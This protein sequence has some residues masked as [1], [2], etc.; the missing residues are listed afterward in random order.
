MISFVV[1]SVGVRAL[2][3]ETPKKVM[4]IT[5]NE[6]TNIDN[7]TSLYILKE[8]ITFGIYEE[9]HHNF[10]AWYR[11]HE[12]GAHSEICGTYIHFDE[13]YPLF[14]YLTD[15]KKQEASD[16][17]GILTTSFLLLSPSHNF[18]LI[19]YLNDNNIS[20]ITNGKLNPV[21]SKQ[22]GALKK[23]YGID[24]KEQMKKYDFSKFDFK[25]KAKDGVKKNGIR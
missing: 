9:Y 3:S 21:F 25:E 1:A 7:D 18:A 4:T 12:E 2:D 14:N 22:P 11:M 24:I 13:C 20:L 16:M 23:K 10:H 15:E 8:G 5:K 17:N 19:N 6:D